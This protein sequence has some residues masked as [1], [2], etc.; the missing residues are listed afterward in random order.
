MIGQPFAVSEKKRD[1]LS[2]VGNKVTKSPKVQRAL[3]IEKRNEGFRKKRR[4][5]FFQKKRY[6]VAELR[7]R[8]LSM[9]EI[10]QLIGMSLGFVC[11]WTDRLAPQIRAISKAVR[12]KRK[13]IEYR[14][15]EK[16][17]DAIRSESRAPKNPH[18]KMTAEHVNAVREVRNGKFTKKMGALKIKTYLGIDLSHQSINKILRALGLTAKR[19]KRKQRSFVPFRRILSND[20]WQVDY[21]EFG[22]GV[23]MLSVKDDYSSSILA[24][25]VRGTCTTKDVTEILERTIKQFGRPKQ[26]LTDHGAQ[27]TSNPWSENH[28]F[29]LWC[30]KNEIEHIMG[31]VRKP[32][33]Q[34]KV[35]RWHGSVLEEA[36]LPPKGSSA[37]EYGKAVLE[38]MEF[39]NN[40]RPHH[41]IGLNV[42]IMIYA[43]GLILPEV[44][45]KVGVHEVS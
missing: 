21:K 6:L 28:E 34:G 26:L 15:D 8:G 32:T 13:R 29:Q 17:R 42:P 36:D 44:L 38:Y 23:H 24:A 11:K 35:E 1:F 45:A 18:R 31:R 4:E 39:Y 41:G 10:S 19:K 3:D 22:K 2:P 25:D 20:L 43:G 30:S 5:D 14:K 7:A 16:I 12:M 40:S 37:E 9:R 27:F 33:T